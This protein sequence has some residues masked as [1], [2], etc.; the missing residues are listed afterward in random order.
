MV[1]GSG[2]VERPGASRAALM[3]GDYSE[4]L[5][6]RIGLEIENLPLNGHARYPRGIV[7]I[8][9]IILVANPTDAHR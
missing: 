7:P 2:W 3:C 9:Q 6:R 8:R 5:V 4:R 1:A